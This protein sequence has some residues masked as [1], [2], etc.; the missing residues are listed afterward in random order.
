MVDCVFA[1]MI[2]GHEKW[3][4][5]EHLPQCVMEA[6]LVRDGQ[7]KMSARFESV[8]RHA[9][10]A[11]V[12][13]QMLDHLRDDHQVELT[14]RWNAADVKQVV[15]VERPVIFEAIYLPRRLNLFLRNIY[16]RTMPAFGEQILDEPTTAPEHKNI[17]RP[18]TSQRCILQRHVSHS[19][20]GV[21][22]IE[23]GKSL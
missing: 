21:V 9:Q 10:G 3:L 1:D 12:V 5:P 22:W 8:I 15:H 20:V 19:M 13:V 11:S 6:T 18:G 2:A 7:D 14:V 23:C 16:R 17:V 4:A